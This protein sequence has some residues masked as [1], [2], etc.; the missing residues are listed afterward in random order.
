MR[1]VWAVV[2]VLASAALGPPAGVHAAAPAGGSVDGGA[3][4]AGGGGERWRPGLEA[5]RA[6]AARRDGA[7]SFAVRTRRTLYRHDAYRL[8]RSASLVKV[9]LMVAYLRRADVRGRPLRG[10]ERALL[11]AMVRRSHNAAAT[12]VRDL[13]GNTALE[14]LADRA[15]MARFATAPSWG[16]TLVTAAGLSRL[17]LRVDRLTPPRHREYALE[18]LRTV[19]PRQRWGVARVPMPGWTL[20]FKG[21][22][23]DYGERDHQ[24]ALLRRGRHRLAVAILVTASPNH[25]Y[26]KRT[27]H[28]VARRL[29][30]GLGPDS[31][32]R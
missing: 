26:G 19:V 27:L 16:A 28:G 20:H 15:G 31:V 7:V 8:H 1:A 30:R 18:L 9:M 12:R 13:V 3:R 5:A 6:Y 10:D 24:I 29:L 25:A 17:M 22:W 11:G 23:G 21:G 32:P 4:D 2:V 14:R